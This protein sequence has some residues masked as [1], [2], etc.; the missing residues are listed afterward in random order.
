MSLVAVRMPALQCEG[1]ERRTDIIRLRKGERVKRGGKEQ[2]MV[3][4]T[5]CPLWSSVRACVFW[6]PS[7]LGLLVL[8]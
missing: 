2:E 1:G 8:M 6:P 7:W 3:L 5:L 4:S